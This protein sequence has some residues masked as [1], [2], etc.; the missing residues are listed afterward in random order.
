MREVKVLEKVNL[1]YSR[2]KDIMYT[3][4][5]DWTNTFKYFSSNEYGGETQAKQAAERYIREQTKSPKP[6]A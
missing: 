2:P 4:T 5:L 1:R 6:R 3:V